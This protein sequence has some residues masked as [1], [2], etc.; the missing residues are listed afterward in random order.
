MLKKLT[1]AALFFIFAAGIVSTSL[2]AD[3]FLRISIWPH[4][5]YWPKY[6][7]ISGVSLGLP[8]SYGRPL[9]SGVDLSLLWGNSQ[10]VYGFKTAP[11]CTGNKM[12]GIQAAIF[13][14]I[15]NF[16]GLELGIVNKADNC[17]GTL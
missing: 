4:E 1:A 16:K 14:R 10:N 9:V 17:R 7:D 6:T 2:H 13:N 5:L 8:S 11:V 3:F 12:N 15:E